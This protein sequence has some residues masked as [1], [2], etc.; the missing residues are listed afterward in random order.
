MTLS[1]IGELTEADEQIFIEAAEGFV[2]DY[3]DSVDVVIELTEITVTS[4][5]RR[6]NVRQS[7]KTLWL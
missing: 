5:G 2:E 1:G 6:R 3:A 7:C 4:V